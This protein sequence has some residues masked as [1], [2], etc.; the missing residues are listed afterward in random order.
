MKL[1]RSFKYAFWGIT[2]AI[3]TETNFQIGVIEALVIIL[4]GLYF[5]IT[6][7]E[8]ILVIILIGLVL[9]AELFNSAI[10]TIV[11]SFTSH[12][13]PGAKLAK[14]ISAGAVVTLII[15]TAIAGFII[16][17]PYLSNLISLG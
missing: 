14:D 16:F 4:A 8:W 2:S 1:I 6:E 11:D 9:S 17:M 10:E 12:Q 3:Q 13:H 15:A 7:L 5:Q